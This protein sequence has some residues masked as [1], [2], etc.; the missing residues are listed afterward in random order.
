MNTLLLLLNSKEEK[1]VKYSSFLKDEII[2]TENSKC[3]NIGIILSGTASIIS[4]SFE[5]KDI[6]FKNLKKDDTFGENLIFSRA[7]FYRG[8][9][10]ATTRCKIAFINKKDLLQILHE[11]ESFLIEYLN[12]QSENAKELNFRIKVLSFD[13][14]YERFTYFMHINNNIFEMKTIK[15]LSQILGLSR[16][17]V[18]RL[19]SKLVNED[20]LVIKGKSLIFIGDN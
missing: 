2:F 8:N 10:I 14:A 3:E 12:L 5:G 16:E 11:N 15:Q 13:N 19:I 1:F 18:S 20:K 4:Y 7:P 17:T 6:V 9:V